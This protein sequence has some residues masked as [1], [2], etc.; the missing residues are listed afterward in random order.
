[1]TRKQWPPAQT[2][3]NKEGHQRA[4]ELGFT[5]LGP[6]PTGWRNAKVQCIVCGHRL[7]WYHSK[8]QRLHRD[9]C[10]AAKDN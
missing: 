1:M 6:T 7:P 2:Q 9:R 4:A 8:Y 10:K 5:T 3:R